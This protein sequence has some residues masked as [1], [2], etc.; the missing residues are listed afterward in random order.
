MFCVNQLHQA[1][2]VDALDCPVNL[3]T[4]KIKHFDFLTARKEKSKYSAARVSLFGQTLAAL[5]V[6][7]LKRRRLCFNLRFDV[8]VAFSSLVIS[9]IFADNTVVTMPSAPR[10]GNVLVFIK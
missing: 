7:T 3:W 2:S 9:P 1:S 10:Y 8:F 6:I 4:V 5:F